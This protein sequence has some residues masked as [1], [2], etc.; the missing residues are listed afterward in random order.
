M[1][2]HRF[3]FGALLAVM[4]SCVQK[5]IEPE[6]TTRTSR[7]EKVFYATIDDQQGNSDTKAFADSELKI[8]WNKDDR[9]TIFDHSTY[10]EEY[11]FKGED[12]DKAGPFGRVSS[13][14]ISLNDDLAG[15]YAVYPHQ[16]NTSIDQNGSISYTFPAKQTYQADSFG[17][18]ANV[19]VAKSDDNKLRFKNV[20][21][22]LSFKLY[23]FT[24]GIS[25]SSIYLK[26]NNNEPLAGSS[27]I[28]FSS[29][30]TPSVSF[31]DSTPIKEIQLYCETAVELSTS[32][33]NYTEFWF[34]LPPVTFSKGFTINVTTP[35]G[36][37][38]STSTSN[39][40]IIGRSNIQRM[41]AIPVKPTGS[42]Y[43][44]RIASL[45]LAGVVSGSEV[46]SKT[47]I[48]K[49]VENGYKVIMPTVT[50]FSKIVLNFTLQYANDGLFVDGQKITSGV[51]PI[52]A[53][54]QVTLIACNG[55]R[56]KRY[57]LEAQNTGLPIVRITTPEG[58]TLADI[59]NDPDH[60]NW[61]TGATI[62]IDKADGAIDLDDTQMDIKGRGNAT[63][64]Y[65]K[66]PYA[67]KFNSE[68]G[69]LGM[70]PSTRWI[71]LANWRDRTLLRNDAAF[72][73][74]KKTN[75]DPKLSP[76]LQYTVSGEFVELEIDGE[77][78]G[79]YYLCEQIRIEEGR[80]NI[81]K[82]N[83]L[84]SDEEK[85]GGFLMEIDSYYDEDNKFISPE[86]HLKYM[87][88]DPDG[89]E[90]NYGAA[91]TYMR[92]YISVFEKVLKTQSSMNEHKYMDYL[93]M[94]SAI[95]FML[96]NELT[97]NR[98]YFQPSTTHSQGYSGDPYA[99]PGNVFGPHSTYLYKDRGGK[100][101]M[102]P[103]WD[104]DYQ[105]FIPYSQWRGFTQTGY[106]YHFLCSDEVFVQRIKDLWDSKKDEFLELSNYI[107]AMASKISLSQEF[108]DEL[109]P[110]IGNKTYY[111]HP[112]WS[113]QKDNGD[114][115]LPFFDPDNPDDT[116]TA[117]YR[118]KKSFED[119]IRWMTEQINNLTAKA[120]TPGFTY[121]TPDGWGE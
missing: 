30:G 41:A 75:T 2:F 116:S 71:L 4:V 97:E 7:A 58:K 106:Y 51:T 3:I 32:K 50:D 47:N 25:V 17:K 57:V 60:T 85:T 65:P 77:H 115:T 112:E 92:D 53:T 59:D 73:L 16:E 104:F 8:R 86:F 84:P 22:Y 81:T 43:S 6:E 110:Y 33:D 108:D 31:T 93:D 29:E 49:T 103:V 38:F 107:T 10:G 94:D 26:G 14:F 39:E 11:Y 79:N 113:H 18:E 37:V 1:K 61:L 114:Y 42:S 91:Y 9:I 28:A 66:K 76:G 101:F 99:D 67:L 119:R 35:S 21:G 56:E 63:W 44:P 40:I 69:V 88:K 109:W 82:M 105:T 72:W 111:D 36:K 54:N 90:S 121:E 19:M 34:V 62:H 52:D 70:H 64:K 89:K 45:S 12:G 55:Y 20:G 5:E 27:V 102:G 68:K 46:I 48:V 24:S 23:G 117:I 95:W 74:S 80:L 98:D 100:L 15:V 120:P 87:F 118:M 78:R 83:K 96:I 13:E